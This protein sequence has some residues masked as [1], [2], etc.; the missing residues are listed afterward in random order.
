MKKSVVIYSLVPFICLSSF[1]NESVF[2]K[3]ESSQVVVAN[4]KK[5]YNTALENF[6]QKNYQKAYEQ[7]NSLFLTNMQDTLYNFYLGRSA[8]ELGKYEFAL[9]AYDRILIVN[10]NNSRARLEMAQTYFKMKLFTQS[11]KEFNTVLEDKKL[12]L[13]VQK[14]VNEKVEYIKKLQKKSFFN[15]TAIAGILY[16][17]NI[18]STPS[19]GS[20][21]IYSPTINSIVNVSNNSEDKSASIYQTIGQLNNKYK[22]SDNFILNSSAT[23]VLMKY[24]NHKEK[25][26]H[27]LSL[28]IS[29]TYLSKEYKFELPILFDK[30]NLGHE[31]YQNNIYLNP[32]YTTVLN[33]DILYTLGFKSGRIS[34]VKDDE[35]DSNMLELENSLKYA[36]S[37]YGLFSFGLNLGKE[38]EVRTQRTDV[39]H[40]YYSTYINNIYELSSDYLLQSSVNYKESLYSDRDINFQSRKR[41]KKMDASIAIIKPI[42]KDLHLNLGGTYT[43]KDSNHASSEYDKYVLKLNLIWNGSLD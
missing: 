7:F 26:I 13:V 35:R 40:E 38:F 33:T 3:K 23:A 19:S 2:N 14:R 28:N 12:P 15:A 24:N 18:N 29:P 30:I 41:D 21:D 16:D 9:S 1:A 4:E 43:K 27:A 17:S 20:F 32:K 22:F 31:S 10:P 5:L 34:F 11:L 42:K 8:Y 25:D 39:E 6:R 37:D 36:S